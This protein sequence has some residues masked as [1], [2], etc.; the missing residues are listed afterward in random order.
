ML[1]RGRL[2]KNLELKAIRDLIPDDLLRL[3]EKRSTPATQRLRDPHHALAR[4]IAAGVRPKDAAAQTGYTIS[5]VYV[6]HSDPTFKD[7]VAKYRDDVDGAYVDAQEEV[8]AAHNRVRLK[9]LNHLEQAFDKAE[10]EGELIPF[11]NSLAAFS[12]LSDRVGVQKKSTQTNINLD[13]A[14]DLEARLASAR[15]VRDQIR[16]IEGQAIRVSETKIARR[17]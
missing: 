10:E 11:R 4:L 12:D 8:Y 17:I 9:A 7:L 3:R 14:K 15:A 6:L 1:T 13:F 5:R 16:Q 2:A